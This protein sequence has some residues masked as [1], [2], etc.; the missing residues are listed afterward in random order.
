M[1]QPT[2]AQQLYPQPT[3][4][5]A[6][7]INIYNPQAYGSAPQAQQA[8]YGYTNSIYSVPQASLYQQPTSFPNQITPYGLVSQPYIPQQNAPGQNVNVPQQLTNQPVAPQQYINAPIAAPAPMA[9]PDSVLTE[10]SQ[11]QTP[12]APVAPVAQEAQTVNTPAAQTTQPVKETAHTAPA[13]EVPTVDTDALIQGLKSTDPEQRVQAIT[14]TAEYAQETPE[15]ALQIVSEPIMNSL[16]DIIKEDTSN[17]QGPS[18]E[19]VKIAEK[20]AK[21]EALTAEENALADKLS[22]RDAANRN[23]I[24]A[25]YTLAMV[26]K[27][28]RDELNQYIETQKANGEKPIESL[29]LQDLT[30]YNVIENIIKNDSF[31][32]VK[33]GAIQAIEH[34]AEPQDKA[35]V[36]ALLADSLKSKD[37]AIKQAATE[38]LAKVSA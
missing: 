9:M 11:V 38:A 2:N 29:K 36:E 18:A 20:I 31:P 15:V 10:Q 3:G 19:Q 27:L 24:F 34:V 32:E 16:V 14:K 1:I 21:G 5:N 17:L 12:T 33:L 13:V 23:R 30:G 8:P 6:V 26:Q 37:E 25:L 4:A 35:T 7:A 28:Q 22:P